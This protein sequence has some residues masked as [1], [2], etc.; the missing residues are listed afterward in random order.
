MG[1]S[2]GHEIGSDL[3]RRTVGIGYDQNTLHTYSTFS[4][5]S[6]KTHTETER[7]RDRQR[8]REKQKQRLKLNKH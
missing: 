1:Q 5:N 8:D 4:V 6:N 2:P 7:N 3:R